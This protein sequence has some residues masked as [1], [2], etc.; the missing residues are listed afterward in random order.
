MSEE[1]CQMHWKNEN[2]NLNFESYEKKEKL[3]DANEKQLE[4]KISEEVK[5][6]K[7]SIPGF[8]LLDFLR[9]LENLNQTNF[10]LKYDENSYL[11]DDKFDLT[12]I[13]INDKLPLAVKSIILNYLLKLVLS[14]KIEPNS[15]KIYGPLVYTSHY[16]KILMDT[17]LR[18]NI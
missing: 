16:E 11:I 18:V 7:K 17:K 13:I 15:N 9:C 3:I 8:I 6:I 1:F 12:S 14:L 5:K 4:K 2:K 10:Y